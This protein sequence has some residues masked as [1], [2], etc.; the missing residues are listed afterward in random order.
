MA[1]TDEEID[2]LLQKDGVCT[3]TLNGKDGYPVPIPLG[4]AYEDGRIYVMATAYR[5]A[6]VARDPRVTVNVFGD[7]LGDARW[8]S[9]RGL[10]TVTREKGR[11]R[12]RELHVHSGLS[13]AETDRWMELIRDPAP[14]LL[15]ITPE[16]SRS[17]KMKAPDFVRRAPV[18]TWFS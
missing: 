12:V 8:V 16:Y 14:E 13:L 9:I 7:T 18:S 5:K 2:R 11:E 17:W 3:L 6:L 1:M 15:E 10:A 4:F